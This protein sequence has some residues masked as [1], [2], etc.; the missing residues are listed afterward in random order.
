MADWFKKKRDEVVRRVFPTR[1]PY[2]KNEDDSISNVRMM[3]V[4]F[5]DGTYV[6]PSMVRGKQL[7]QDEAVALARK[8][9]LQKYPSFPTL[10]EAEKWVSEHHGRIDPRG[11]LRSE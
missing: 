6:I 11:R 9:G 7:T 8:K 4:G 3:T 2:K 5:D 10:D 1:H